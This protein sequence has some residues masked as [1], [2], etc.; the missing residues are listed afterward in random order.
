M[1]FSLVCVLTLL[2]NKLVQSIIPASVLFLLFLNHSCTSHP[3]GPPGKGILKENQL[4]DLLVDMHYIEG[5]YAVAGITP[6]YIPSREADTV[7][8]Y[9]NTLD[10][11]NVTREDFARS[12]NYYSRNPGQFEDIYTRVMDILNK[13]L[14]E[15]EIKAA[16]DEGSVAV[17]P[18][19]EI[20]PVDIWNMDE[21][22]SFPRSD[23]NRFL[24]FSIPV[25]DTGVYTFSAQINIDPGDIAERPRVSIWFWYDDG[26]ESGYREDFVPYM[27][28]KDGE[29][30]HAMVSAELRDTSITH[31][32]G[33]VLDLSNPADSG[34]RYA[35]VNHI[36]LYYER[37]SGN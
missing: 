20:E 4:V 5:M 22:W 19:I 16:E 37:F 21:N 13:R 7:D 28:I 26:T 23:T 18:I 17:D 31:I 35:D 36:Q 15:A 11:H 9:K 34:S 32:K 14:S 24:S 8:F 25:I 6:E 12:L 27:L 10:K 2:S 33:R 3:Q 30:R 29:T 1:K